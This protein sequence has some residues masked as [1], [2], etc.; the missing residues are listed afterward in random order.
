MARRVFLGIDFG[1]SR[2][3]LAL[4]PGDSIAVPYSIVRYGDGFWQK[5]GTILAD[6][7]ITDIVVGLPIGLSGNETERTRKTRDFI[8]S[9]RGHTALPVVESDERFSSL[10]ARRNLPKG[11]DD[12]LAAAEILQGYLDA[13]ARSPE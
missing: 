5:L 2:V 8:A 13:H 6:E 10:V 3:G 9:L 7:K 12:A 11:P 1:D 4:A